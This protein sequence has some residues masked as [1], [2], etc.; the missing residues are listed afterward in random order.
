MGLF[1]R[2]KKQ[3][4]GNFACALDIGTEF[5]KALVFEIDENGKGQVVGVGRQRQGLGDM[6]S[7][8]VTDIAGVI[9]NCAKALER[10]EEMAQ[11]RADQTVLGIA[12]EMVKGQTTYVHYERLKPSNKIDLVEL[13]NIVQK[14]QWKAFDQVRRQLAWETGRNEVDVK[15]VNAAIVDVKIDGFKIN[16]PIGFQGKDVTIGIFN[17]FA[18]LVHLGALQTIANE[19]ELD[20]LSIAAEPYAVARCVSGDDSQEF[21]AVFIDIGGGTTDIAVV[22]NGG[23]EGTKM[24]AL[25]GRAFTKRLSQSLN[26]SFNKAEE[27]KIGYSNGMLNS[28]SM[29]IVKEAVSDDAEVWI[30][31]VELSLSEFSNVDLLPSRILLCGGGSNLPDIKRVLEGEKW[32]K[33]LP[34]ARKPKVMFIKPDHVN[35]IIDKTGLLKDQ[36]D[37]TPMGLANIALDLAG[38]EEV[39]Q[40]VLRKVINIV[41][42]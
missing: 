8:A 24:F 18:P 37:I 38:E 42:K 34:F 22:R 1:D 25:G 41:G 12:G 15:L 16:N 2:L 6:H 20:I 39:L 28:K 26:T 4:R 36:Q 32:Y 33:N 23:V 7:G 10:A 27:I 17:A 14:V 30:S 19:L 13:R 29:K 9:N 35:N 3:R 31:G 21:S 40:G 5:V 11:V